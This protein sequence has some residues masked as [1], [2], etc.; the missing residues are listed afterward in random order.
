[1]DI[2]QV[3]PLSHLARANKSDCFF[4]GLQTGISILLLH[5]QLYSNFN[6]ASQISWYNILEILA[7]YY[8][9]L[10]VMCDR[11]MCDDERSLLSIERPVGRTVI[12]TVDIFAVGTDAEKVSSKTEYVDK[13]STFD[14]KTIFYCFKFNTE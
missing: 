9:L 4:A 5:L 3:S 13:K 14:L 2:L 1:L 12:K 8:L 6:I 11:Q 7:S 10:H